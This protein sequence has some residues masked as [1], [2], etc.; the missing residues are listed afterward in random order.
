MKGNRF[1]ASLSTGFPVFWAGRKWLVSNLP[2]DRLKSVTNALEPED[3]RFEKKHLR[4]DSL[5]GGL[6]CFLLVFA[7]ERVSV[8]NDFIYIYILYLKDQSW[9]L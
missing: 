1:E 7:G 8:H 3:T 2:F 4:F 9:K 6:W 5:L